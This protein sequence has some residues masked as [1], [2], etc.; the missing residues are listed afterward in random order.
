MLDNKAKK[1]VEEAEL[2]VSVGQV[3]KEL[4]VAWATARGILLGLAS[5][6]KITAQKTGKS[7]IFYSKK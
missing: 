1:Y 4:D 6:G 3:A 5:E 2:P 7:W